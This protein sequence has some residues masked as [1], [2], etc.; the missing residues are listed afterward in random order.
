M[1]IVI[2]RGENQIGGNIIEI[3]TDK[4]RILLDV[5]RELDEEEVRLPDID[6]L[7]DDPAFDAVFISHYHGDHIGLAYYID[8]RIPLS[9]GEASARLVQASDAYKNTETI[10]PAGF[11]AHG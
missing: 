7:F 6:G 5:G 1:E 9:L 8:K 4:T 2:H 11:P 3:S 10:H